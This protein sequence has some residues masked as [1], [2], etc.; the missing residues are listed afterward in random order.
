MVCVSVGRRVP[1]GRHR[2]WPGTK[3][4]GKRPSKEPSRRVRYDRVRRTSRTIEQG[5]IHIRARKASYC[6]ARYASA[7]KGGEIESFDCFTRRE[8]RC[9]EIEAGL[10]SLG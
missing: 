2:S 10:K 5:T 7:D 9:A 4:L 3:C 1:E 6:H 8:P